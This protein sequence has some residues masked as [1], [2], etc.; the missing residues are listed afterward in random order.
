MIKKFLNIFLNYIGYKISK[1]KIYSFDHIYIS[2]FTENP[3][4]IDV[5]ANQGESV[6]RFL[7]I[8]QNPKI[9]CFEPALDSFNVLKKK[10]NSKK[11]IYLN[12]LGL[13]SKKEKKVINIFQRSCN[14]SF[15][16][17]IKDSFWEQKKKIIFKSD[18]L[19]KNKQVV[20]MITMDAYI[21]NKN[22]KSIDLLKIDTQGFESY[23]L[24]GCVNS[25]K[26]NIIKFVEIEFIMGNQYTNRLNIIDLEQHLIKNNF[27]LY[28]I[29]Q[30]GDLL[31][32]PD[33]CFDLLYANTKFININ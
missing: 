27:R 12:N 15:N 19:I 30:S 3:S 4:I 6:D 9:H 20:S 13:S 1:N 32:K 21:K 7:R 16:E 26:N 10:Y 18:S 24:K 22:I 14:S 5:G 17:P 2:F 33:M 25:F 11:N 8:F 28:G 29:N 31:N 23:V